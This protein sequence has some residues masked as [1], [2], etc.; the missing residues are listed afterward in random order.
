M[1]HNLSTSSRQNT[2]SKLFYCWQVFLVSIPLSY[3][4]SRRHQILDSKCKSIPLKT[5]TETYWPLNFRLF[6]SSISPEFFLFPTTACSRLLIKAG[7]LCCYKHYN[8]NDNGRPQWENVVITSKQ[9]I[10]LHKLSAPLNSAANRSFKL[11]G[12]LQEIHTMQRLGDNIK[13]LHALHS[14]PNSNSPM[15]SHTTKVNRFTNLRNQACNCCI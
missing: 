11:L 7:V 8:F 15:W 4:N 3:N 6:Y 5:N 1:K 10:T 14:F 2:I 9:L 13:K 12:L